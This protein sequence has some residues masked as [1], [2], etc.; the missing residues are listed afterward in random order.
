MAADARN[1]L[2]DHS[3]VG[4][5]YEAPRIDANI[6]ELEESPQRGRKHLELQQQQQQQQQNDDRQQGDQQQQQKQQHDT[7]QQQGQDQKTDLIQ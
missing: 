2:R 3:H 4:D 5:F 6:D 7:Q 1:S